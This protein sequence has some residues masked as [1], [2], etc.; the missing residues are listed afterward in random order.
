MSN[1][2]SLRK[3]SGDVG[4]TATVIQFPV[5]LAFAITSHKIQGQTIPW[6]L[7]VVL[8][9][10]S[11]FEDAQAHVMLSR[12]QRLQQV[13]ILRSLDDTK[14]R[15]SNIGLKELQRLKTIS[16][17]ENPTPWHRRNEK[18]IKVVSLNCA[19]LSTHFIDIQADKKL[20]EADIIHLVETSLE[21]NEG[22][23]LILPG[24]I[25]HMI[26][27]GKGKGIATYFKDDV[28]KYEQ[29]VA[30]L[31]MQI[32]KF[33]SRE[34]DVINVYRSNKGNTL[35]LSD[36]LE[37]MITNGK[38]TLITG[39]LNICFHHHSGNRMSKRLGN[40]GFNQLV[41]EAT[42]ILGGHIDHVYWK[43]DNGVWSDPQLEL[44]SPY[45]SDHDALCITLLNDEQ[46]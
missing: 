23:S 21:A 28:F 9:L 8:D 34:V 14:I 22:E 45:Y 4:T 31:Y 36:Y 40:M 46:D 19:G 16:I 3:K 12:V 18:M 30:E 1:Q 25:K 5:K 15:T 7:S 6:P 13:Y 32:I 17:N 41:R 35:D 44:N 10:N 43:N 26:N 39:D 42:H 20:M 27:I 24:Y 37:S 11:I 33:T 29:H 38:P 2:Y